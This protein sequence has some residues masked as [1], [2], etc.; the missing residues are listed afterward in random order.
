DER[1]PRLPLNYGK[2]CFR[3]TIHSAT[4]FHDKV[5]RFS[6]IHAAAS[7]LLSH[8]FAMFLQSL[9]LL[10][11]VLMC[12]ISVAAQTHISTPF[13]CYGYTTDSE[14]GSIYFNAHPV[15]VLLYQNP[16]LFHDLWVFKCVT[17]VIFTSGN[18]GNA[19]G[20]S[21]A[22]ENGLGHAYLQM[23]GMPV[24]TKAPFPNTNWVQVG[25][26]EVAMWTPRL[27]PG[28]HIVYL[29]LPD[30]GHAG[31]GY[32]AYHGESL[33]RL[34]NR[35]VDNITTTNGN[36]TYTLDSLHDLIATILRVCGWSHAIAR[37]YS[38]S[39]RSGLPQEITSFLGCENIEACQ[40]G[41]HDVEQEDTV[42]HDAKYAALY[43][44]REYYV[45]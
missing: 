40:T 22:L 19:D 35:D 34:W 10:V 14:R 32:D 29:R 3:N 17:T 2:L 37:R 7:L 30:G 12:C 5:T 9:L 41:L 1:L 27:I 15:D 33:K 13:S 45:S 43:L 24:H 23:T 20:S 25:E 31:Q 18:H 39:D 38:K 28:F 36:T 21:T 16:D 11:G 42:D 6:L 8:H 44:E 26:H 4:I